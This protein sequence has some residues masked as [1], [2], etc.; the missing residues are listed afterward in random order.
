MPRKI[1]LA[2][3]LAAFD[4]V[5]APK[6]IAR[7]NDNEVRLVKT[8]G[9]W[10]WHKHEETDELFLILGGE[11]EMAFRDHVLTLLPG[12]LLVV[13]KGVEHRPA[14]RKGLVKLLLIDPNGTPNTGDRANATEAVEL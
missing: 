14:T 4:D 7:Y 6:I 8:K 10:V 1:S 11:F 2:D 9:E 13:P 12:D 3:S 5:G